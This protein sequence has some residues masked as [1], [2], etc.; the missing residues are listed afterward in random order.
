MI[1]LFCNDC[2]WSGFPEELVSLTDDLGDLNFSHCPSCGGN[3][4]DEEDEEETNES[5]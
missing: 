5:H 1:T 3:N 2:S 4:F